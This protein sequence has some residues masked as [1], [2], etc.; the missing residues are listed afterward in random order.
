MKEKEEIENFEELKEAFGEKSE[1]VYRAL[2]QF[3]ELIPQ[4]PGV[5]AKMIQRGLQN[6]K[7]EIDQSFSEID[8]QKLNQQIE[9]GVVAGIRKAKNAEWENARSENRPEKVTKAVTNV[10]T[11][12]SDMRAKMAEGAIKITSVVGKGLALFGKK[13]LAKEMQD[14]VTEKSKDF[15]LKDS[16]IGKVMERVADFGFAVGDGVGKAKEGVKSYAS[17]VKQG[18]ADA[19]RQTDQNFMNLARESSKKKEESRQWQNAHEGRSKVVTETVENVNNNFLEFKEAI[20]T[21]KIRLTSL[22]AKGAA[23]LGK[24]GLAK[25][26][27]EKGFDPKNNLLTK[28]SRIGKFAEKMAESGFIKADNIRSGFSSAKE[29]IEAYTRA[30]I[31]TVKDKANDVRDGIDTGVTAAYTYTDDAIKAG[32]K[33]VKDRANDVKNGIDTGVTAVYTYTDDAI[34]AGKKA[35]KDKALQIGKATYKGFATISGIGKFALSKGKDGVNFVSGK[36]N[37]AKDFVSDKIEDAQEFVS[38]RIDDAKDFKD[39]AQKKVGFL[40]GKTISF[41]GDRVQKFREMLA[42]SG[43]DTKQKG[44]AI[45][46]KNSKEAQKDMQANEREQDDGELGL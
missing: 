39:T 22:G 14:K 3:S 38:D 42:N 19:D 21:G 15:V 7:N 45:M 10:K 25:K 20:Q 44:E 35:A 33:F 40:R 46:A 31:E 43:K 9:L 16:R 34:K 11:K 29:N 2:E 37:D 8:S 13:G 12:S 4:I 6:A 41:F 1:E 27:A 36:M 24:K 23:L 32:K 17:N 26:V 5:A 28:D 18:F 30:G